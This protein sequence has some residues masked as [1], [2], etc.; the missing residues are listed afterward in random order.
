MKQANIVAIA[1]AIGKAGISIIRI[2]GGNLLQI[3]KILTKKNPLPRYATYCD[4]FD[5]NNEV[6]DSGIILYFKSPHSF[7]GEDVIELHSHGG[8]IVTNL[9]LQR[10]LE[11]NCR[12]A[13]AGEFSKRAFLNG[14]IDLA[15]AESIADLIDASS[16]SAAKAAI[17]SLK[18][19]FSQKIKEINNK[20]INLRILVEACIDFSEEE[21][22]H[23]NEESIKKQINEIKKNLNN[24]LKI[25]N[26]GSILR[27]GINI[28]LIGSPNV[29]KSSLLN[30]FAMDNI[31]IVT[32]IAGTTR[33]I[34]KHQISLN[35]IPIN[36]IDTAGLHKTND[37]IEKIGIQKI[38]NEIKSA[39]IILLISDNNK[40]INNE[41]KN[42][43]NKYASNKKII[44]IH[45]KIDLTGELPNVITTDNSSIVKISIKNNLGLDLLEKEI[46]NLIN[47]E[48]IDNS[49]FISRA[50][51]INYIKKSLKELEKSTKIN[52]T[53][54]IAE[55]LRLAHDN[56][57]KITGKFTN[58]DILGEIFKN[59]CIGK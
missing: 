56:L 23:I 32:K 48:N 2:S 3:A 6:I 41:T 27:E 54:L 31:A 12:L 18:G 14:K 53:D 28:I 55:H 10:C 8:V 25:A 1:T 21:I 19:V 59:F 57:S 13:E 33:D 51:H 15:Q 47:M 17:K 46:L 37:I 16:K 20:I 43:I 52:S 34:I 38:E 39:D 7:T 58:E 9:L 35:G 29:G 50:R 24:I 5:K 44:E 30:Y 40:I 11:L 42:I 4:F 45:N 22:T 36:I 26:K 49:I